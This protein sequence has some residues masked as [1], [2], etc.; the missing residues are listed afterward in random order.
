VKKVENGA[1]TYYLRSSV[2]GGQ[3]VAEIVWAS[4]SW[5]WNRGYVF[6]A[7]GLLAI[8]QNGVYWMHED[9]IT[10][11]KR[12]TNSAGTTVSTIE[13]DPWGADAGAAWSSNTA[14]QPKKFTS[15]DRDGNGSDEAMFRR[16]NRW[17]SRF[18]QPDPYSGS[19]DLSNPQSF[20]RYAYVQNDPVNFVDPMGLEPTVCPADMSGPQCMGSGF[21]GGGFN[22]NDRNSFLNP[23]GRQIIRN[24][25]PRTIWFFYDFAENLIDAF[26]ASSM[27]DGYSIWNP[28]FQQR[29]VGRLQN[30]QP[31]PCNGEGSGD[32]GFEAITPV[33]IGP[34]GGIQLDGRGNAYP[35]FGLAGGTPGKGVSIMVNT[36]NVTPG[37]SLGFSA[38]SVIGIGYSANIDWKTSSFRSF[39]RQLRNGT[40]SFG[41][42]SPGASVNVTVTLAPKILQQNICR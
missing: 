12:V 24:G 42:T 11:S 2:F 35:Y 10:K 7:T 22:M 18:D 29:G 15:Y 30:Q 33:L 41:G 36:T 1:T 16:H 34:K 3:I 27:F 37:L 38:G 9:P 40:W 14:F 25:E 23:S 20:N 32:I 6:G 13:L 26:V 39:W 5:Q 19:Y 4:V 28:T 8:Q 31:P 21:W 17:H